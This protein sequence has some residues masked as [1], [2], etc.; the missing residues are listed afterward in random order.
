V[1]L[2]AA[3]ALLDQTYE[4]L[5]SVHQEMRAYFGH[6]KCGSTWVWQ[7]V[8]AVTREIGLRHCLV[9]AERMPDGGRGALTA[10]LPGDG[11]RERA[12]GSFQAAALQERAEA[13][14]ADI[15][16]CLTADREQLEALR[17]TRAFHVI[18]DPRDIVV[19]GYFSHR[20]SHSTDGLPELARHRE[21]LAAVTKDEG[22]M[23]EMEFARRD[24]LALGE[25]DYGRPEV[26]EVRMEDLTAN[27]YEGFVS[28]FQ[29]LDLLPDAEPSAGPELA[30]VWLRRTLN[31]LSS[32]AP[33]GFLRRPIPASGEILLGAVYANRFEAKTRGR[34]A[35]AEDAQ[36][37]YRKGVA[38]DWVNHFS[39]AHEEAF[40][41]RFE[42]LLARL[43]YDAPERT[44]EAPETVGNR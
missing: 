2:W 40:A 31:R 6:H 26:L 13:A 4:R 12:K 17:A 44:F 25:W 15:V 10:Q 21:H 11:G 20:N 23:L 9:L 1:R 22:L 29:H 28:I 16:S 5:E 42:G 34:R 30:R 14:G 35:G 8:S 18:R 27:P 36:S 19:S 38:G 41:E 24:L 32:R 37:H 39:P 33:L 43:G 7:V 3:V